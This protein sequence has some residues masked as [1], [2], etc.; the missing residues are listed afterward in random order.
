[1]NFCAYRT[2]LVDGTLASQQ[3]SCPMCRSNAPPQTL[4]PLCHFEAL[5]T[6]KTPFTSS[7]LKDP[8]PPKPRKLKSD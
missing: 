4:L 5:R 2:E 7:A 3:A 6:E 1:M 8:L